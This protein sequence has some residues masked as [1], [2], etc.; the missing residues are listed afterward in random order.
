[1]ADNISEPT[2]TRD[3]ARS[4]AYQTAL[5]STPE[6]RE[7]HNT[8]ARESYKRRTAGTTRPYKR[9]VPT[10]AVK[11]PRDRMKVCVESAR[12]R[13][14]VKGVPFNLTVSDIAWPS[15]CP[16][17]LEPLDYSFEPRSG[18]GKG[19]HRPK[20]NAPS[21]DRLLPDL[22][23]IPTNVRVISWKA[24]LLKNNCVDPAVF[25]RLASYIRGEL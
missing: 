24:N 17:T 15:V 7:R 14:R 2:L 23:Y 4:S 5:R 18:C 21:L 9:R 11:T 6:G 10:V 20:P 3:R 1:M 19:K 25:E 16:V 13:A 22:G 8:L 12:Y